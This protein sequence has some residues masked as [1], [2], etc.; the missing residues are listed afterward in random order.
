MLKVILSGIVLFVIYAVATAPEMTPEQKAE[1]AQVRATERAA[2]VEAQHES[3]AIQ[4]CRDSV[5]ERYRLTGGVRFD[6]LGTIYSA[7]GYGALVG[8]F[9]TANSGKIRFKCVFEGRTLTDIQ[10]T[11]R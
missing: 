2:R 7:K 6:T 1:R 5:F 10:I 8:G 4:F 9:G 11:A 3:G